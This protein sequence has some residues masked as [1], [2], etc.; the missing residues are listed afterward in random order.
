MGSCTVGS[1]NVDK[2]IKSKENLGFINGIK[3]VNNYG[4]FGYYSVAQCIL[5]DVM[6]EVVR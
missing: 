6:F 5:C 2:N 1:K 3:V 4:E